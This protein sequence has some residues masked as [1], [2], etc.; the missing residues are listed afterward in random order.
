[1]VIPEILEHL[2]EDDLEDWLTAAFIENQRQLPL[3]HLCTNGNSRSTS[4]APDIWM[5][6]LT[7][8][9]GKHWSGRFN[10]EFSQE[11]KFGKEKEPVIERATGEVR[12]TLDTETAKVTFNGEQEN[13]S[14]V[15]GQ[16]DD[17]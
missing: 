2:D 4:S 10:V 9:S 14:P 16:R 5:V 1:M 15:D 13:A 3:D 17:T 7:D 8:R 6:E 12:F 11:Q